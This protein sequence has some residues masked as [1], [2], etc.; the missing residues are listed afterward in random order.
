MP[1]KPRI[2][3]LCLLV[4]WLNAALLAG[5][6]LSHMAVLCVGADGHVALETSPTGQRCGDYGPAGGVAAAVLTPALPAHCGAC[7]DLPLGSAGASLRPAP[8]AGLAPPATT[9]LA[10]AAFFPLPS[11]DRIRPAPALRH[12][13]PWASAPSLRTTILL[14]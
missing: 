5:Q 12:L 10:P 9:A 13:S 3:R 11:P 6:G 4:V 8:P 1:R 2:N 7:L 14:I